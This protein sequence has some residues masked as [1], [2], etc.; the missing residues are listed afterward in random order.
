MKYNKNNKLRLFEI[1]AG[2]GSQAL[3][4]R[5]LREIYPEFDYKLVGWAEY[6]PD[7]LISE[8]DP[9]SHRPIDEQPAVIA[10]NALH[11]DGIG[12]N[13]GDITKIT[14][15]ELPDFDFLTYSTP[16]QS[17]SQAG[18]QHGFTEGSGTRSSIIWNVRDCVKVKR[19][20]FLM[21]EN[22]KAMISR[23]FIGMFNLWQNELARLGYENFARV[24]NAKDFVPQN[25]ERIFLISIRRDEE[26]VVKYYF[27]KPKT[28]NLCLGDILESDV[29]EKY[30]L[31]DEMLARFCEKS[32]EEVKKSNIR[33]EDNV[34][35]ED[36]NIDFDNFFVAQ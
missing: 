14:W 27:P 17:I 11:P 22:V 20:K 1:C 8:N 2:Y 15:S 26:E 19:P 10:H 3:A 35:E 33:I 9:N 32:L 12:K 25:R 31:S 30:F 13:W 24:I 5:R 21:L 7:D 18:L 23:K 36:A 34:S 6:D 16:C 4:L 28:L 29:D